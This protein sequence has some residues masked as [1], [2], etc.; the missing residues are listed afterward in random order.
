MFLYDDG[1]AK[2]LFTI[3]FIL[4]IYALQTADVCLAI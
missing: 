3:V 2:N 1:T 4:M